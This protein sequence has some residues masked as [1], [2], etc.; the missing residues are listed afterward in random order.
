[1]K[2]IKKTGNNVLIKTF[3]IVFIILLFLFI[4]KKYAP[5]GQNSLA[6]M[7]PKIQYLDFFMYLKDVLSGENSINYSFSSGLGQDTIAVFSYYLLSPFNIFVIFFDKANIE[8]F[9]NLI[10]LLKVS[11]AGLTFAYFLKNRFETK[12][13]DFY[14]IILSIGYALSQ[15][16][17]AQASNVMW[18]DGVYM[19]PLILLGV[20]KIVNNKSNILLIVSVA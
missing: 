5:F 1:M 18:L 3:L 10:F 6:T 11:V 15:Y 20:Y 4:I 9:F 16:N 2:W 14:I 13:D 12:L 19:L 17:I 7:D 8:F